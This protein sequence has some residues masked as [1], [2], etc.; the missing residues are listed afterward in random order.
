MATRRADGTMKLDMDAVEQNIMGRLEEYG[1]EKFRAEMTSLQVAVFVMCGGG[2]I[3]RSASE[4]PNGFYIDT[5]AGKR[6][7]PKRD[8][9]QAVEVLALYA[10]A[11]NLDKLPEIP[12]FHRCA[13][14]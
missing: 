10:K 7:Y 8:C 5:R 3:G 1:E 6:P 13:I 12:S 11:L 2:W 14:W 4:Q 9:L